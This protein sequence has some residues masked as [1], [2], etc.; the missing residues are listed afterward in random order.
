MSRDFDWQRLRDDVADVQRAQSEDVDGLRGARARLLLA[1]GGVKPRSRWRLASKTWAVLAAAAIVIA[2]VGVGGF[3]RT[4]D[5]PLSFRAGAAQSAA[6]IGATL[7][8]SGAEE[9]P[10]RFSD[11]TL[12]ALAPTTRARV[13]HTTAEG[14][15]V[16]LEQGSLR[17]AVVHRASSEWHV[18]AGPFRVLVTGTK[19]DVSWNAAER[20]FSLALQEGLVKVDGPTLGPAGRWVKVGER[21]QAV[22][23]RE[24]AAPAGSAAVSASLE[25]AP[26]AVGVAS[27]AGSV[28]PNLGGAA[29]G[30]WKELA[31]H[32]RYRE[33]LASAE[34]EGFEAT[35]GKV[36]ARDLVSLGNAARFAGSAARAEQAF[37]AARSR[38]SGSSEASMAAFYLGRIAYDQRGDRRQ[39]VQWFQNYL[40][41]APGGAFAREAAGRLLEAERALGD[42]AAAQLAA[43]SYLEK[44]PSG[45]HA[46]L[47][48][49]VLEP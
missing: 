45:P 44:Y 47:A 37:K 2:A 13:V 46:G 35:C 31:K 6:Q 36:S 19:F 5:A 20:T 48:R 21:L 40:R 38:F 7:S 32:Q 17:V 25:P 12:I 30:G 39:A 34:A 15:E 29:S 43:R 4:N 27:A 41:E 14:A 42:R 9:L 23:E 11:G 18:A 33:A 1:T 8:A 26:S 16:T 28:A 24:P 22:L 49:E 10:L 3:K